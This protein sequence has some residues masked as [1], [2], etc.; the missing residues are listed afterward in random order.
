MSTV[1][2][3][4]EKLVEDGNAEIDG[5]L[6]IID[7][8]GNNKLGLGLGRKTSVHHKN[9]YG[10]S[11]EKRSNS[12]VP[13]T[14]QFGPVPGWGTYASFRLGRCQKRAAPWLFFQVGD[15]HIHELLMPKLNMQSIIL[16]FNTPGV[17]ARHNPKIFMHGSSVQI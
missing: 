5:P 12:V 8:E 10:T 1:K 2:S 16:K 13:K 15:Q 11:Y 17:V 7:S 14:F 6:E 9:I 4:L 3:E